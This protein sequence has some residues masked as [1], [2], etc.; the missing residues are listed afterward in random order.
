MIRIGRKNSIMQ[1]IMVPKLVDVFI[2]QQQSS[3]RICRE[4][5]GNSGGI[6][7]ISLPAVFAELS[8]SKIDLV[9]G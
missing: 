8:L 5:Y 1:E 7:L 2:I 4:N 6:S 9:F 3:K